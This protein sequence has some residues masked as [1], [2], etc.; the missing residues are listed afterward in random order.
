[1]AFL[2][3]TIIILSLLLGSTHFFRQGELNGTFIYLTLVFLYF[4]RFRIARI[5]VNLALI[6]LFFI[7]IHTGYNLIIFRIHLALPWYRLFFIM[8]GVVLLTGVAAYFSSKE[9]EKE[10]NKFFSLSLFL[11]VGSVLL[12]L[13]YKLSFPILVLDRFANLGLWQIFMLA[14]YAAYVGDNFLDLKRQFRLRPKIWFLFSIIFF[15][16]LLLGLFV[17][18]RFLLTGKLHFPIPALIIGGPLYR[19]QGFFM[20]GLFVSTLLLVGP[21]WC[22]HLCYVGGLDNFFAR[23]KKVQKRPFISRK[24]A[25]FNLA[26]V[27]LVAISWPSN[28]EYFP[29]LLLVVSLFGLVSLGFIVGYSWIK[30]AMTHCIGFCPLGLISVLGGKINPFRIRVEETKCTGC[31]LCLKNCF[32]QA[33]DKVGRKVKINGYCTLCLACIESCP[34]KAIGLTFWG[35]YRQKFYKVYIFLVVSLHSL[36]LGLARI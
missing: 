16:Q 5:I 35:K 19:G 7:W 12:W 26:L 2:K 13:R 9:W 8:T 24:L 14:L 1:M 33:I 32:Y 11:V 30:G 20:L 15:G 4:S 23:I 6:Y 34:H 25:W 36:F 17:D 3:S 18:K 29:I 27:I 28:L 22:S 31:G 21:A 10:D